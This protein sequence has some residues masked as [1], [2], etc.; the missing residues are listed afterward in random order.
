M[1]RKAGMVSALLI[2]IFMLSAA[3]PA[4]A[5]WFSRNCESRVQKAEASLHKAEARH[6]EHS[7]QAEKKRHQLEETRERCGHRDHH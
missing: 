4:Q 2:G 3:T 7:A 5:R 1:V 6:G